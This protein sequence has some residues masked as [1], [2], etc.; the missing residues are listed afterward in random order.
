MRK[1]AVFVEGQMES[2]FVAL[3]YLI[4]W[5]YLYSFWLISSIFLVYKRY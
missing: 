3:N 2:I 5:I 4:Y 1:I